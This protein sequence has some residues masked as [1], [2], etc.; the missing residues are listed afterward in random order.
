MRCRYGHNH[1][2]FGLTAATHDERNGVLWSG[3][4]SPFYHCPDC[5]RANRR[6]NNPS[7]LAAI[8][9]GS[10]GP[11]SRARRT[12]RRLLSLN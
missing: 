5:P 1:P 12:V 9:D 11:P 7:K 8:R 6:D 2:P 4:G 3:R 10:C